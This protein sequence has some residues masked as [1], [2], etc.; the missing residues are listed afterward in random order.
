VGLGEGP[1]EFQIILTDRLDHLWIRRYPE[2][3]AATVAWD[4]LAPDGSWVATTESGAEFHPIVIGPDFLLGVERDEYDVEY[5]VKLRA[6]PNPGSERR[7]R[8]ATRTPSTRRA[9]AMI[10]LDAPDPRTEE[11][12]C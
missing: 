1:G 6:G 3:G 7:L 5:V 12:T 2:P 8:R 10:L 9:D 4:I 11:H